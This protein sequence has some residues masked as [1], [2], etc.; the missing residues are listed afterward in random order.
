VFIMEFKARLQTPRPLSNVHKSLIRRRIGQAVA[1]TLEQIFG[2]EAQVS[3]K[4]KQ[5]RSNREQ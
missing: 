1:G 3:L 5:A 4:P 2:T